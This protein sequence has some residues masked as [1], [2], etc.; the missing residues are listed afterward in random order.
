MRE[1]EG[2]RGGER[3]QMLG[4]PKIASEQRRRTLRQAEL[5]CFDSLLIKRI[6]SSNC[7]VAPPH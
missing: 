6:N 4:A 2:E 1:G 3:E 5:P 7:S